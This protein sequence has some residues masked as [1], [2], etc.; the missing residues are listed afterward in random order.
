MPKRRPEE[1]VLDAGRLAE[2]EAELALRVGVNEIVSPFVHH[3]HPPLLPRCRAHAREG[4]AQIDIDDHH[5]ERP[6][7]PCV[8]WRPCPHDGDAWPVDGTLLLI[9]LDLR[10]VDAADGQRDRPCEIVLVPPA[11]QLGIGNDADGA[12]GRCAVHPEDFASSIGKADDAELQVVGLDLQLGHEPQCQ[13]I[14]PLLHAHAIARIHASSEARAH[15]PI[16]RH[17]RSEPDHVG[18]RAANRGLELGGQQTCVRIDPIQGS[19]QDQR[20][21]IAIGKQPDGRR[22]E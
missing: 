6:A 7:I 14:A 2:I 9:E 17:G 20:L 11:L 10:D 5:A 12:V 3:E 18:P 13:A 19:R 21:D 1:V 15:D 16:N 8:D 22:G 4:G